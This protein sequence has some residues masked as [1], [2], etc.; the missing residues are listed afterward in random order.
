MKIYELRTQNG[1]EFRVAISNE[2][3]EARLK[4]IIDNNAHKVYEKFISVKVL[5]NGVHDIKSFKELA[6]I[7]Y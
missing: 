4:K 2:A 3:Q 6:D 5:I 7:L 1:R